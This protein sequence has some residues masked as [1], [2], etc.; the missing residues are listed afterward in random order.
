MTRKH[1]KRHEKPYGC[2]FRDCSK[3]FG[4]KNDWKRHESSQ[5]W[6]LETW[7][8]EEMDPG[9][10]EP[11]GRVCQRRESF[12]HHLIKDH[13]IKDSKQLEE[14]FEKCRLGRHCKKSFWCGFCEKIQVIEEEGA[15][16]WTKRCNHIDDHFCGRI[17][18]KKSI[19]KWKHPS[20]DDE[21]ADQDG[22]ASSTTASTK[23]SSSSPGSFSSASLTS[24][25]SPVTRSRS[26]SGGKRGPTAH[27][28]GAPR[29]KARKETF[30]W[31]CVSE[32]V[33]PF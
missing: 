17:G 1:L 11:C 25:S 10:S 7:K 20:G 16:A 33:L 26:P 32:D 4:S 30:M 12:K 18:Q 21:Q 6:Q 13:E 3:S 27:G 23:Q 15:N 28:D 9:K 22:G 14:K 8:C 2:T 29:K 24:P 31:T 5:H 19:D